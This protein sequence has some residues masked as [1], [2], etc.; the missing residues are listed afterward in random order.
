[1]I[2]SGTFD[3]GSSHIGDKSAKGRLYMK[4]ANVI[5]PV[6]FNRA[7][8]PTNLPEV[9]ELR[10]REHR[11][12]VLREPAAIGPIKGPTPEA[13]RNPYLNPG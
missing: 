11:L 1:M 13:P 8:P 9:P 4:P 3:R 2:G 12:P 6:G 5:Q 10:G 7:G